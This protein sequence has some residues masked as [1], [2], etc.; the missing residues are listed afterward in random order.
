M[1]DAKTFVSSIEEPAA[2]ASNIQ[3]AASFALD[4]LAD[5]L[6]KEGHPAVHPGHPEPQHAAAQWGKRSKLLLGA[7]GVPAVSGEPPLVAQA[8]NGFR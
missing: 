5:A 8:S 1:S 2:H 3:M 4:S 6:A 7:S